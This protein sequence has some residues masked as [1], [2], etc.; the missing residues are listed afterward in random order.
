M[1]KRCWYQRLLN[2]LTGGGVNI[3][4]CENCFGEEASQ[5][6]ESVRYL[7]ILRNCGPWIMKISSD[8][9]VVMCSARA[10]TFLRIKLSEGLKRE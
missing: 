4:T 10:T 5:V 3:G 6:M 9:H 1:E 2:S 7:G 8:S